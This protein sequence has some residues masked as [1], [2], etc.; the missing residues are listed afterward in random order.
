MDNVCTN[1]LRLHQKKLLAYGGNEAVLCYV[2][3]ARTSQHSVFANMILFMVWCLTHGLGGQKSCQR[4][5]GVYAY[6]IFEDI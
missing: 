2:S 1:I 4:P 3:S 5:R 6:I